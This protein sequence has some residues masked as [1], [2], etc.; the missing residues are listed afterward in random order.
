MLGILL[1]FAIGFAVS[2]LVSYFMG[3]LIFRMEFDGI[4][5]DEYCER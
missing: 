4:E 2:F 3:T 5:D 1:G